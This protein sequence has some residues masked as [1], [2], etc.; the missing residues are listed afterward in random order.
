MIAAMR[1]GDESIY[2]VELGKRTAWSLY[3][4]FAIKLFANHQNMGQTEMGNT[5]GQSSNRG[6]KQSNRVKG[7]RMQ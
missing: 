1:L 5:C 7:H 4:S 6:V 2:T 3:V